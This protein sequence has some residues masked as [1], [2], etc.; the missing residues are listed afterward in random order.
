MS[1]S[2]TDDSAPALSN[3]ES[4]MQI[5]QENH[6]LHRS[7]IEHP[8]MVERAEGVE[9]HLENG[10]TIID[11][12]AGAA[13]AAVGHGRQEVHQAIISQLEKVS[14]VHTQS[15]TTSAAEELANFILEGSPY[16]LE[17]AFFV[18]SGSEAVESA[19]K[20]ARQY[21]YEKGES[22]RIQFISRRQ[23]YHGNTFAAM[24][25]SGNVARKVPYQDT[26][27]QHVSNV[28]PAYA[29]RYKG[30]EESEEQFTTRL[31][32]ELEDEFLNVGPENVI[33]F[34]AE[35]VVGATAGCVT[36]PEGYFAGVRR[37]CNKYGILLILD[38]IMCGVGR[39]GSFFAFE[40]EKDVVPDMVTVAKGLGGGYAAISGVFVHKKVIDALRQGTNAYNHGHTYQ[41]HP[42][43]CAA[44]LAV[45]KIIRKQGLVAQCAA[46]GQVLEHLLRSELQNCPSVGHIRGRGLFWAV[47]F[48][49]D[50]KTKETFDASVKFGLRVQQAAFERGVAVYPGAGTVDGVRGDHVLLAPPFI[51]TEDQLGIICRVLREA[52]ESQEKLHGL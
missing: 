32:Q 10:K 41:A 39:T 24:S 31:L 2:R 1:P 52:I 34:I 3:A 38:E 17:K 9:L 36:A 26:L 14:Y 21:F 45:Q 23:S 37:L 19:L 27:F 49:R 11:A 20:L 18:G 5:K 15:Y 35:T 12:C 4:A 51:I 29:Y 13:V 8:V 44:A 43:S 16:G 40:Q 6:L 22:Q 25:I 30:T 42:I 50:R 33:A 48:V 46:M 47:E 7:L 28:S